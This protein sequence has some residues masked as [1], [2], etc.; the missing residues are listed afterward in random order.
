MAMAL[1]SK[2]SETV[3]ETN[4]S[5]ASS[6]STP[7][8]NQTMASAAPVI[9]SAP[10]PVVMAALRKLA[11]GDFSESGL[12]SDSE[13]A[14]LVEQVRL[15]CGESASKTSTLVDTLQNDLSAALGQG[16]QLVDTFK[17]EGEAELNSARALN[18]KLSV[19]AST[20][21][22]LASQV[23]DI[24]QHADSSQDKVNA[25]S[26]TAS[27][28]SVAANEIASKTQVACDITARA[29]TN[30]EEASGLF[31][32]LEAAAAEIMNVTN[33]IT[34]VSD[35]TKLLALNATIEAARAGDAGQ[36]FAVVASEV[37]ELAAQTSVA[38]TDIKE[39]IDI[40]HEAIQSS[41]VSM[42]EVSAVITQ[43][44]EIVSGIAEAAE[45]QSA[46]TGDISTRMNEAS[47]G[48][49]S[50]V[51]KVGDTAVAIEE[52]NGTASEASNALN[53]S[54]ES[55]SGLIGAGTQLATENLSRIK[56]AQGGAANIAN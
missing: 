43:V 5:S 17:N 39:K 51:S 36:G 16:K 52:M 26:Q 47:E 37:K 19:M 50:V 41:V 8:I 27:D 56:Q 44:N 20:M 34:E 29:V 24:T 15:R 49:V 14:G 55:L 4:S 2:K 21:A 38:N 54:V 31:A 22:E 35:Q 53:T 1:F 9:N 18:K 28:L 33:T 46:S 13:L 25:V 3:N 23:I 12:A 10:A 6:S 32:G 40:I 30:V 7:V 45:Q 11:A 48:I 42:D